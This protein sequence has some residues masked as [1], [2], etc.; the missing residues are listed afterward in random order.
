MPQQQPQLGISTMTTLPSNPHSVPSS[1]L[2]EP[3]LLKLKSTYTS[4]CAPPLPEQPRSSSTPLSSPID[5]QLQ[6]YEPTHTFSETQVQ[7]VK[8]LAFNWNSCCSCA[9]RKP[10]SLLILISSQDLPVVHN[11]YSSF[12][13]R[14]VVVG[15]GA[16]IQQQH[17]VSSPLDDSMRK[18]SPD[19]YQPAL[20]PYTSPHVESHGKPVA[21]FV[22]LLCV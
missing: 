4:L 18:S 20:S 5:Q 21:I 13:P 7:M 2:D 1:P 19:P 9:Q 6:Q 11:P 12:K 17:V 22:F 15:G 16:A 14:R 10:V 8:Q 3:S